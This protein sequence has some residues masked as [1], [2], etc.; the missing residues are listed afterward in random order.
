MTTKARIP[1]HIGY[2][3]GTEKKTVGNKMFD[4]AT[5]SEDGIYTFDKINYKKPGVDGRPSNYRQ[6][7]PDEKVHYRLVE[8]SD[9]EGIKKAFPDLAF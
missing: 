4:R 5:P 8:E 9:V 1:L 2:P 3:K 7:K 6:E